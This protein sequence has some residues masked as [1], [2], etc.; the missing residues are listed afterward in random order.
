MTRIV[1]NDI[2]FLLRPH[3][4]AWDIERR[5]ADGGIALLGSALFAGQSA[6]Q[7]KKRKSLAQG[8]RH[9]HG[10]LP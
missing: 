3:G 5:L 10:A 2:E 7:D 1:Y 9:V 8:C 4:G 6:E